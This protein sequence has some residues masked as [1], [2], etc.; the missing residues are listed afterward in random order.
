MYLRLLY[1]SAILRVLLILLVRNAFDVSVLIQ[2]FF[3][4]YTDKGRCD[5]CDKRTFVIV[6]AGAAGAV[7][8]EALR[9]EGFTVW[10]FQFSVAPH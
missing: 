2:T 1:V 3:P 9:Q 7:A 4:P 10:M 5:H 6:G 8:A